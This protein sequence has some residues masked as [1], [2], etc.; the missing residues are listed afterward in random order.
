MAGPAP[1]VPM[2]PPVSTSADPRNDTPHDLAHVPRNN[3]VARVTQLEAQLRAQ[4][5]YGVGG[6][7]QNS[8][9]S[10][11]QPNVASSLAPLKR[12]LSIASAAARPMQQPSARIGDS[13][14]I[15][16][17]DDQDRR[18]AEL[19]PPAV[20]KHLTEVYFRNCQN[21]PYC[22]FHEPRM[23]RSLLEQEVPQYLMLA[24]AASAVRY[25]M[26]DWYKHD[27]NTAV[28][29]YAHAAWRILLERF[30]ASDSCLDVAMAQATALLAVVDYTSGHH[31]LGWVKV[32]LAI[33]LIQDLRLNAEPDSS[34]PT[35]LQEETRRVF[36][37]LYL[38]DK[39][40]ACSRTRPISILDTDCTVALPCDE[41]A[42]REETPFASMSTLAVL[43]DP[44]DFASRTRLNSFAVLILMCSLLGRCVKTLVQE[45]KIT[46]SCWDCRSEFA[47]LSSAIMS[48]ES[49]HA[50]GE[51]DLRAHITDRFGTYDG[52][53][54][55]KVGHF[56]WA[57]AIY[58]LAGALLC[59]P[60]T[61]YRHRRACEANFPTSFACEVLR[62]CQHHLTQLCNLLFVVQTTGC[63]ARGSFLGYI[64][65]CAASINKIFSHSLDP[66]I[67]A[68]TQE[69]F[70]TCIRFLEQPPVCWPNYITMAAAVK[71][72][73]LEDS[74]AQCLTNVTESC[75]L[76]MEP[77]QMDGLRRVIDYAWLSDANRTKPPE[78]SPHLDIEIGGAGWTPL[79]M[80]AD[81]ASDFT[82]HGE[83]SDVGFSND[84]SQDLL[85]A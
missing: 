21:Q 64:A 36:W 25:S 38:L 49:M 3:L 28:E 18:F 59:H 32:G 52:F 73:D 4:L 72:F 58:H 46:A 2:S 26:H 77:L 76:I 37:S 68:R 67:A 11:I 60:L 29:G 71:D 63:C 23:R 31:R 22:F 15:P 84:L 56:V 66:S 61:L 79:G 75:T 10:S 44:F 78:G 65:A 85:F 17:S 50:T 41:E 35:W 55:Q 7:V 80:F 82:L 69:Q 8:R 40:F 47:D 34:L 19:P 51:S 39:F 16:A 53:D 70:D 43:R 12:K 13:A 54:R 83:F 42:F 6:S 9:L 24:M 48:F 57:R 20:F 33:R 14:P 45:S 5:Q 30:F 81:G 62:R 74:I 1:A 27:K